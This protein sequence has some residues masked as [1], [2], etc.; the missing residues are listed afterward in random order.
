MPLNAALMAKVTGS[1]PVRPTITPRRSR[2]GPSCLS[3][4]GLYWQKLT[5]RPLGHGRYRTAALHPG[6]AERHH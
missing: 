2:I 6:R 4:T 3:R 1:S 5:V